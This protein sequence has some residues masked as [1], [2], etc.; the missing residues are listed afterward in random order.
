MLE[1]NQMNKKNR[2][3]KRKQGV[4]R[5]LFILGGVFLAAAALLLVRQPSAGTPSIS[6]EPRSIDYGDVKFDDGRSFAIKVTNS[7][8]GTLRFKEAPYI[9]VLEGC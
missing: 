6:V 7:G 9:Q 1:R 4:P 5:I 8:D 2:D 3:Q